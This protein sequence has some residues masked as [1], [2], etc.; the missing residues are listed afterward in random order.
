VGRANPANNSDW[1]ALSLILK[2]TEALDLT[3]AEFRVL[4]GTATPEG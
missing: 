4:P 2:L 3:A 1:L